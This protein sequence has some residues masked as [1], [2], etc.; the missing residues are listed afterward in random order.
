M[1]EGILGAVQ[2][3]DS[4]GR[5]AATIKR[6][7]LCT[8]NFGFESGYGLIYM[9]DFASLNLLVDT[10]QDFSIAIVSW[11]GTVIDKN[12]LAIPN[13]AISTYKNNTMGYINLS[14]GVD[15]KFSVKVP[16]GSYL[17]IS[18]TPASDSSYITTPISAPTVVMG[19]TVS[20]FVIYSKT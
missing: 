9:Y 16:T 3:T 19:D 4:L 2:T 20:T 5:Y 8:I 11:S 10:V 13:V 6:G 7:K 12:G 14:T 17:G 18:L 15:G 1:S